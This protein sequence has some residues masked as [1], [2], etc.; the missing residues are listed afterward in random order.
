MIRLLTIMLSLPLLAQSAEIW[1]YLMQGEES[2]FPAQS[3]ITDI[4]HFSASIQADGTPQKPTSNSTYTPKSTDSRSKTSRH[5]RSVESRPLPPLFTPELPFRERI[6]QEIVKHSQP[7]DG[8]QI[9]F[10]GIADPRRNCLLKFSHS[11]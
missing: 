1:A 7:Y 4:A 2:L 11:T 3:G 10:E 8:V 9:D 5:N 6:I